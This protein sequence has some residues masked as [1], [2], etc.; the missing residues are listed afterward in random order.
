MKIGD[1]LEIIDNSMI[2]LPVGTR[3][4]ILKG[5]YFDLEKKNILVDVDWL[6][7]MPFFINEQVNLRKFKQVH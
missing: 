7:N 1:T 2:G 6:D 5:P 4:K 3:C